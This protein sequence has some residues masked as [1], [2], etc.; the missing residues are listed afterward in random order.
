M[1]GLVLASRPMSAATGVQH[2]EKGSLEH[3]FGKWLE[4]VE[5]VSL[6]TRTKQVLLQAKGL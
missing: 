5:E 2:T 4:M 1:A 3:L 6:L